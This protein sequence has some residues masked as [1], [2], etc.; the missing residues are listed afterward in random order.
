MKLYISLLSLVSLFA[1]ASL[2]SQQN[3]L[4]VR[5]SRED[6][7]N[8]NK[9]IKDCL[10]QIKNQNDD[11][12]ECLEDHDENVQDDFDKICSKID[13]I[14]TDIGGSEVSLCEKIESTSSVIISEIDVTEDLLCSKIDDL[15]ID[16]SNIEVQL[17]D[18][19]ISL[20][21]K[22][23]STSSVI[24]SELDVT[25]SILCSK[26][27]SLSSDVSNIDMQLMDVEISLCDKI[28][29]TS[30]V[31]TS[32][33]DVT[34]SVLCSKID[35][36]EV[37]IG[38]GCCDVLIT[39]SDIPFTTTGAGT[40][41]CLSESVSLA[42]DQTG[43]TVAH[44]NVVIDLCGHTITGGNSGT[45]GISASEIDKLT[46][47][48]GN[49]CDTRTA[50]ISVSTSSNIFVENVHMSATTSGDGALISS[51][52]TGKIRCCTFEGNGIS[53]IGFGF[54][55]TTG[56]ILFDCLATVGFYNIGSSSS[57][58]CMFNCKSVVSPTSGFVIDN[59]SFRITFM[60]CIALN[61]TANGFHLGING[62]GLD[63][64]TLKCCVAKGCGVGSVGNGIFVPNDAFNITIRNC[65]TNCNEENGINIVGA[66]AT[67]E[68]VGC[69]AIGN[70]RG[71]RNLSSVFGVYNTHARSNSSVD[72]TGGGLIALDTA[73]ASILSGAG[74][75]YWT[76]VSS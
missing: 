47:K 40:V 25:E 59:T 4:D 66:M 43:I 41:Y 3:N 23:E 58:I 9:G 64:V 70:L 62:N 55:G 29:S 50:S 65:I 11:I 57:D 18:V 21:D 56:F 74:D 20:C 12:K 35:N 67:G 76:N 19:E 63:C 36:L 48:N 38:L 33:L 17:S 1:I 2:H 30:S 72:F 15:I 73:G 24:T 22:I 53:G 14:S 10:S 34:E 45:T 7:F 28:E 8:K 31:I 6:I 16:V 37:S 52:S 60:S 42:Q 44:D 61:A 26:M 46:I 71:V 27:D 75:G 49:I 54:L 13:L 68:V 5:V 39:Q 51:S 69:T 32:E